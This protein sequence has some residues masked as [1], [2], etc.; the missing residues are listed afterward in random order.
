MHTGPMQKLFRHAFWGRLS[1]VSYYVYI[2]H[3]V[4]Q[5]LLYTINTPVWTTANPSMM[6]LFA[7]LAWGI[8]ALSWWVFEGPL[9]K[10]LPKV[11]NAIF[12][13]RAEEQ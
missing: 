4:L 12:Q 1:A 8:G 11:L 9:G 5:L 7:I 3:N 6:Y 10:M 13:K 2:W